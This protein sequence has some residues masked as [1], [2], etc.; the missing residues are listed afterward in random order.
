VH[1]QCIMWPGEGQIMGRPGFGSLS[2]TVVNVH[3]AWFAARVLPNN[4]VSAAAY[5]AGQASHPAC[6]VGLGWS[7]PPESNRRPHPYHGPA[8]S[9]AE[10]PRPSNPTMNWA[11]AARPRASVSV[12]SAKSTP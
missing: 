9:S 10:P 7:P 1:H 8:R 2:R 11:F 4:A 6:A 12:P 5:M 3:I